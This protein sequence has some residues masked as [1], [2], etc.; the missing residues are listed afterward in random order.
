M[1]GRSPF[2]RSPAKL[3]VRLA[4]I[5]Y[6]VI[7]LGCAT[8]S[9]GVAPVYDVSTQ[10]YLVEVTNRNWQDVRVFVTKGSAIHPL[11]SVG[12][13]ESRSFQLPVGFVGRLGGIRLAARPR[14]GG[15]LHYSEIVQLAP[16]QTLGWSLEPNLKLS[17]HWIR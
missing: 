2:D 8:A 17:F 6:S 14:G 11:G 3:G 16:G 13:N 5:L 4:V 12:G 15:D 7:Q 10:D 1:I 9:R